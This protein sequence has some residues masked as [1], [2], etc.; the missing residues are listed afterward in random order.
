MNFSSPV[1]W[2]AVGFFLAFITNLIVVVKSYT[3]MGNK[4]DFLG[5][6]QRTASDERKS[7][8]DKFDRMHEAHFAHARQTDIHQVSMSKETII[9]Y[10]EKSTQA[11][12]NIE[13]MIERHTEQD[14]TELKNIRDAL[15]RLENRAQLGRKGDTD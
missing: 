13:G 14:M 6:L 8:F 1:F 7:A 9:A 11:I 2:A 15:S 12:G 10:F 5:Q 4:I 3:T